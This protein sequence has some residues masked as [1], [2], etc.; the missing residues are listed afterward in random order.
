MK[1]AAIRSP[2]SRKR[3]RNYDADHDGKLSRKE[4]AARYPAQW[5]A[6]NDLD[7]DGYIDQREWKFYQTRNAAENCLVAIR[8]GGHGDVTKSHVLWRFRKALPNTA[9]PLLYQGVLY[10]LRDGI[11]TSLNP[12]TGEVYRMARLPGALGSYW[13]SPVAADGKIFLASEEGKIVVVRADA[14][15]NVAA[16]SNLDEDIFSTPAIVDQRIYLRT[17]SALYCFSKSPK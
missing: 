8:A 4:A 10:L 15:W 2:S 12:E 11:F 5:F 13:A 6:D 16:V 9:S 17:M 14:N 7:Q 3:W 1:S